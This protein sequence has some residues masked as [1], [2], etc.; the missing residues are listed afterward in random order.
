[1]PQ[2]FPENAAKKRG[3]HVTVL[4]FGEERRERE[5]THSPPT[6]QRID[7]PQVQFIL[8][9]LC[10]CAAKRVRSGRTIGFGSVVAGT[11]CGPTRAISSTS[12]IVPP[13]AGG[14]PKMRAPL[15]AALNAAKLDT[16]SGHDGQCRGCFSPRRRQNVRADSNET[17]AGWSPYSPMVTIN[18]KH[19]HECQGCR[20]ANL[21]ITR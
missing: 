6:H 11:S 19:R 20:N 15:G 3:T 18:R 12:E 1:M 16:R 4:A 10:L 8:P 13:E 21:T 9:C 14:G 17:K 7:V 5:S 2:Q